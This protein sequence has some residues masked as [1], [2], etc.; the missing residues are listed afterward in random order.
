MFQSINPFNNKVLGEFAVWDAS[1]IEQALSTANTAAE[2]WRQVPLTDR[3]DYLC[4]VASVLRQR[5]ALLAKI[6]TMEMG[7][8]LTEAEAEVE[9][10]AT[11]CEYYAEHSQSFLADQA[12]ASDATRSFVAFQPLGCIL[13]V[14]PWNFPL[15][16]VFR[17][18]APALM[19]GNTGLLKHASNVPQCALAI[20]DVFKEAGLPEG[21]FSSLM[22]KAS[23]VA[24]VIEDPRVHAVT[25]TGS[26]PA[27]RSVAALAGQNLK[28]SVLELGG[29]DA[30]IVLD[31]ADLA[32]A[33]QGAVTSRF[34]NAGQSCIAAKRFIVVESV[35][36]AFVA[37]FAQACE[38]LT[39]GDPLKSTTR[40]APMARADLRDEVHQQVLT[41]LEQG[42]QAVIGCELVNESESDSF[43]PASIIDNVKPG[44]LAYEEEL[45]GPVA[46]VIRVKDEAEALS[47]A[48]SSRFG[49]GGSVWTRDVQ[50]GEAVARNVASGACF[51]N[52][53]V[54]S[55][56]R[57]PFG[58]IKASGYGRELAHWGMHEFVNIKTISVG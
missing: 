2:S 46:S 51:V 8:L 30:F 49:L 27:G 56:P 12:L 54:K 28:K 10:C 50:R 19:A 40:L 6:V 48:N 42:G 13:A 35:A 22:I 15:W 36:D 31:D 32:Q 20:E 41:T 26:E 38:G 7:K 14:M 3:A 29:A 24:V 37:S 21:V 52:S 11:V 23:Q 45:F 4:R 33:V 9:K 17:F 55:D 16:Q 39:R 34:L 18:A 25:L 53:I 47:V 58:G 44:M 5:K 57:L 43:Y 1:Q